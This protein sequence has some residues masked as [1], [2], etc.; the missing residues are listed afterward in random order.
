MFIQAVKDFFHDSGPQWAAAIAYYSLLSTIPLLLVVASVAAFF[1]DPNWAVQQATDL[2]GRFLPTD[3][4]QLK[5]IVNEAIAARGSVSLLSMAFLLWTG[6]RVFGTV[7]QALNIVYDVDESYGFLK[8][9]LVELVMVLTIG[10]LF[11]VALASRWLI[12]LLWRNFQSLPGSG[13]GLIFQVILLLLTFFLLYSFVP[14][15]Q[16]NWR[17][18]LLGAI[19]ATLLILAARP[20]FLTYVQRFAAYNLIYGSLAIVIILVFWAWMVAVIVIFAG[21]VASHTQAMLIEGQTAQEV[22][23]EHRL[24]SPKHKAL[25]RETLDHGGDKNKR[26]EPASPS[27]TQ[28]ASKGGLD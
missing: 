18:A 5:R 12:N 19:L 13:Q 17:A 2:L 28:T 1:V 11:V 8:R 9:I 20:L 27:S 14:R 10:L 25:G 4:G 22:E 15:R 7:T 21:E 16:V 23:R 24:R 26:Q 6:T 3:G